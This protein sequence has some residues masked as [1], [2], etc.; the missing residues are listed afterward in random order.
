MQEIVI[1]SI[2]YKRPLSLFSL[3]FR[4]VFNLFFPKKNSKKISKFLLPQCKRFEKNFTKKRKEKKKTFVATCPE[5][6]ACSIADTGF[7]FEPNGVGTKSLDVKKLTDILI[8]GQSFQMN[9][10]NSMNLAKTNKRWMN[11]FM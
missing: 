8:T 4:G 10:S 7:N 5:N 3:S 9:S 1:C 2:N 11:F 6:G